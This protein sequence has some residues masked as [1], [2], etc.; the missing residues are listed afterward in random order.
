MIEAP[1]GPDGKG[2]L[3][4]DKDG[5]YFVWVIP[6][7]TKHPEEII[8]FLDWAW[9]SPEADKF[10]AYGIKGHNYTEENGTIKYDMNAPVN[11]EKNAFQMY[12]LSLNVREIGF[13]SPLVLKMMPE[14]DK[15]IKG[16]ETAKANLIKHDG[17]HMPRLESLNGK[18]ELAVGFVNG[19]LF[20]DMFA[21]VVTGKEPLDTA[22]NKFVEEWK[23]RGG[24]AVIKE[25]TNWYNEFHK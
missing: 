15:I 9:S 10:F 14:S 17:L 24:D 8:K 13:A 1:K 20:T 4:A 2:G 16:Y 23:K 11:S 5:I 3:G 18:P 22:F 21:K 6:S 12:Q 7:K 19:N 25:A